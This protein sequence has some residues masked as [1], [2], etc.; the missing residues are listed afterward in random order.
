MPS[1]SSSAS[2]AAFSCDLQVPLEQQ[3]RHRKRVGDVVETGCNAI[4]GK[5]CDEWEFDSQQV[6]NGV[7]VFCTIQP[8]NQRLAGVGRSVHRL[9]EVGD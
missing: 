5:F 7:C 4:L 3:R 2:T 1:S 6:P 8:T 9:I